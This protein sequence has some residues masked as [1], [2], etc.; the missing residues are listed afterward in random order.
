[1]DKFVTLKSLAIPLDRSNIDTEDKKPEN[2][3]K[4]YK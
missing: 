1:M 4:C 3:Q 2:H